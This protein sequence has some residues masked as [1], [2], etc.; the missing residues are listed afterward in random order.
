RVEQVVKDRV[1][2]F[3]LGDLRQH[4]AHQPV[5]DDEVVGAGDLGQ[6][7]VAQ[8]EHLADDGE[9]APAV[10]HHVAQ[11]QQ[12]NQCAG[13]RFLGVKAVGVG[14]YHHVLVPLYPQ[15]VQQPA[16]GGVAGLE[17][18]GLVEQVGAAPGRVTGQQIGRAS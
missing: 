12:G 16:V 8:V 7:A 18:H 14:Q 13:V 1:E 2:L 4:Q 17:A 15:A 5:A 10:G 3:V 11:V 9:A 6:G